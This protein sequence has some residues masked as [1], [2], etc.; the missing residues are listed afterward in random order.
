MYPCNIIGTAKCVEH[1]ENLSMELLVF[2]KPQDKLEPPF[3]GRLP[4]ATK[5]EQ[6]HL[7]IVELRRI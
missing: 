5:G 2:S 3:E 1:L 6:E 7:H 4:D